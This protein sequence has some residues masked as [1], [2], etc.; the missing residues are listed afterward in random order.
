MGIVSEER[1]SDLPGG[2]CY[3][4]INFQDGKIRVFDNNL[5]SGNCCYYAGIEK[6]DAERPEHT[7]GLGF[8]A[9]S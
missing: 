4:R 3:V 5:R 6:L 8:K 1:M 2:F 9:I 7:T